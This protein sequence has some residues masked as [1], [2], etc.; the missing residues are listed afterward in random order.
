MHPCVYWVMPK[1]KNGFVQN[2]YTQMDT[3]TAPAHLRRVR[4][5]IHQGD[6]Q[7]V[8]RRALCQALAVSVVFEPSG[9][10]SFSTR[11]FKMHPGSD[12]HRGR[13]TW[14]DM[15]W[16]VL[17]EA[18]N[19]KTYRVLAYLCFKKCPFLLHYNCVPKASMTLE[20]TWVHSF[21]HLKL[22]SGYDSYSYMLKLCICS[23]S[24]IAVLK[25]K[26]ILG[27][28][29]LGCFF[30]FSHVNH[31]THARTVLCFSMNWV[32]FSNLPLRFLASAPVRPA[33]TWMPSAAVTN[34]LGADPR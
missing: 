7:L 8:G 9:A 30:Y 5:T 31:R 2:L 24:A 17:F 19:P 12:P 16:F 13:E 3:Y 20:A 11:F 22:V 18:S 27:E 21:V 10:R 34:H 26:G 29:I 14:K 4:L 33:T 25:F 6:P 32:P 1:K 23:L 15:M 28:G